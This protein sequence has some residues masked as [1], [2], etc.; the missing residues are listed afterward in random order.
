MFSENF[1]DHTLGNY[2]P[3]DL[4]IYSANFTTAL[5]NSE[6]GSVEWHVESNSNYEN[7]NYIQG[8]VEVGTN[9]ICFE[10]EEKCNGTSVRTRWDLTFVREATNQLNPTLFGLS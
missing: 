4:L 7:D 1:F 9:K 2:A 3:H 6:V 10:Q 5:V 8:W